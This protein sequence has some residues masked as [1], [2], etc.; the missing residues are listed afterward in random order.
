MEVSYT[1]ACACPRSIACAASRTERMAL[2]IAV[3]VA[4]P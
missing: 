3:A 2:S 1:W 4:F